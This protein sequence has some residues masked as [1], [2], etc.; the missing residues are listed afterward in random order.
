[1]PLLS[2]SDFV[3]ARKALWAHQTATNK[4]YDVNVILAD[5]VVFNLSRPGIGVM[6]SS[7]LVD[8]PWASCQPSHG[9]MQKAV[10][11]L[12]PWREVS[13]TTSPGAISHEKLTALLEHFRCK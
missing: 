4:F 7:M 9:L 13:V 10:Y 11:G 12:A 2:Y 5:Q 8:A 3:E 1:M 6:T